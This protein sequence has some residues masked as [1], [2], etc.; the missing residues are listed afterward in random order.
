MRKIDFSQKKIKI[1]LLL[2]SINIVNLWKTVLIIPVY[3]YSFWF[4]TAICDQRK[5][6]PPSKISHFSHWR[7]YPLPLKA[8]W[9]TL[10][11]ITFEQNF[12][13]HS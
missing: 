2:Y 11:E 8:I 3:R 9:K 6:N 1:L 12:V 4:K 5:K 13:E 10:P 7:E